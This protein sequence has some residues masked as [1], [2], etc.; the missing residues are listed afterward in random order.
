MII[1]CHAHIFSSR[2]IANVSAKSALVNK[3]NLHTSFAEGRTNISAIERDCRSSG[4]DACLI[5]PTANVADV[6][7]IN[8]AFTELAAQSDFLFT[9]GT[10]HPFSRDNRKELIR[11]QAQGIRAIKLC[12]FSQ[13]FSL[14]A[15]ETLNL[16]KLIEELNVS[17]NGRFFVIL[18]TFSLAHEY[19]GTPGLHTTTPLLLGNIVREYPGIDFVA[20]HMGGLAAP[21]EEIFTH[22]IPSKNL[23]L[24]T[25]NAAHTL[26]GKDFLRL[27]EIH[28]PE[29][30]LFGTDWPWFDH[31][32]EIDIITRLLDLAGYNTKEKEKVFHRNIANLLGIV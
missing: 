2:I 21:P 31:K 11:L 28:G 24:D 4:V 29:H 13:G 5:L 18:D 7:K 3:I 8:S 19:F 17:R 25:S 6:R 27:L 30:I 26:S 20:A 9:A 10:L 12:S 32:E 23:F 22:L 14:S 16:F 15:P 1:D